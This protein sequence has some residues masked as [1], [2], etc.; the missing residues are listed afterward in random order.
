[1][2]G[3][4]ANLTQ[5][6]SRGQWVAVLGR[7]NKCS[8]GEGC[9]VFMLVFLGQDWAVSMTFPNRLFFCLIQPSV[10]RGFFVPLSSAL[11]TLRISEGSC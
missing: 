7:I 3:L 4:G 8:V 1:M 2:S 6:V 5:T 11:A 10:S 9:K